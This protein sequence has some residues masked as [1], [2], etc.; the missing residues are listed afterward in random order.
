MKS[1]IEGDDDNEDDE[2]ERLGDNGAGVEEE[3]DDGEDNNEED[4]DMLGVG[5]RFELPNIFAFSSSSYHIT[6]RVECMRHA[7]RCDKALPQE[8]TPVRFCRPNFE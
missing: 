8:R 6:S 2:L 4:D 5:G 1:V 7:T 3:D